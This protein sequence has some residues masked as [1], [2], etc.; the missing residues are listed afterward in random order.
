MEPVDC[1]DA[2]EIAYVEL[3]GIVL[4]RSM[5]GGGGIMAN[6][7]YVVK[8]DYGTVVIRSGPPR[9]KRVGM[10]WIKDKITYL[11]QKPEFSP[12]FIRDERVKFLINEIKIKRIIWKHKITERIKEQILEAV[13]KSKEIYY[14]NQDYS[15]QYV[16]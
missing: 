9:H 1:L 6:L 15:G 3:T 2:L 12:T 8:T 16:R 5:K 11:Y 7:V 14:D 4:F 13:I 10:G